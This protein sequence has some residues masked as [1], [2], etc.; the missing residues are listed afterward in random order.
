MNSYVV[1]RYNIPTPGATAQTIDIPHTGSGSTDTYQFAAFK[2][3]TKVIYISVIGAG[4]SFTIDGSAVNN[5][6]SHRLFAGNQYYFNADLVAKAKFKG[7]TGNSA[8]ATMYAS[9][10]TN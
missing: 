10:L 5:A 2:D 1:N 6:K 8:T 7:T 9:E 3:I 4:V